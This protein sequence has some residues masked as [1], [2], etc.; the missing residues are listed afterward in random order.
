MEKLKD[1]IG[2]ILLESE[3]EVEALERLEKEVEI[4]N[5]LARLFWIQL[6]Q[7]FMN[8][9]IQEISLNESELEEVREVLLNH[10]EDENMH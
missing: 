4:D 2:R 6:S 3:S 10:E 9:F 1:Q 5:D 7:L 8:K